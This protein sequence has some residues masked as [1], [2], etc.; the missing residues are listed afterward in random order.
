MKKKTSLL[1]LSNIGI[2]NTFQTYQLSDGS[3]V[4]V[5]IVDTAGQE[6]YRSL[7][8][9]YYNRAD[10]CLLVYDI[11]SKETF[12]E[13]ESY[14]LKRI[15]EFCKKDMKIILLGN[16]TD[17]EEQRQV[18]QDEGAD[19]AKENGFDFMETSCLEN[20]NV[21]DGF[22]TLI[23]L[24]YF[25]SKKTNPENENNTINLKDTKNE[26]SGRRCYW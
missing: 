2:L 26:N 16:K 18:T 22:E 17:L 1:S 20:R 14:F 21:A 6:R 11:T 8:R 19:F 7:S 10:G 25:D 3:L 4:K 24:A 13:L 5:D 9:S 12:E 23:E 15:K